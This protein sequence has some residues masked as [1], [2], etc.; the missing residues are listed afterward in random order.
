M[1]LQVLWGPADGMR[2]PETITCFIS[3]A[4]SHGQWSRGQGTADGLRHRVLSKNSN[5]R[6][7]E[8]CV[9]PRGLWTTLVGGVETGAQVEGL[10]PWRD[11]TQTQPGIWG[12]AWLPPGSSGR[13]HPGLP[14]LNHTAASLLFTWSMVIHSCIQ[15]LDWARPN[16]KRS[17]LGVVKAICKHP[18]VFWLDSIY[19]FMNQPES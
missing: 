15:S 16:W 8:D 11:R 2:S 12:S 6:T 7:L 19:H 5:R 14:N 13:A 9:I 4:T 18:A 10:A 1:L 17:S 3:K